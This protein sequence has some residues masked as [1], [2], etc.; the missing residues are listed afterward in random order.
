MYIIFIQLYLFWYEIVL[1][2]HIML[3][4]QVNRGSKIGAAYI[5]LKNSNHAYMNQVVQNT[6]FQHGITMG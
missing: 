3:T 1:K 4:Q 6:E 2:R 5:N